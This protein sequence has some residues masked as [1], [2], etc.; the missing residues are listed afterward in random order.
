M[1]D[2][3]SSVSVVSFG[4]FEVDFQSRRLRKRGMRIRVEEQPFQILEILLNRPGQVVTRKAL[5]EKLWPNT[6]VGYEHSLNTAVN[7]MRE[8][9]GDS[10]QSPRF[11][12]TVPR[13][14]YRFIAPVR[15]LQRAS[16]PGEKKMLMA[17]PF[18][19][20]SDSRER[21]YFADGLTEEMI[22]QLGKLDPKR[23]GVI[24]RTSAI[25]Y[26]AAKKTI[27]EIAQEL[28]VDYILEGSVRRDGKRVR[29]TIQLIEAGAQT[30]L[31]SGSYDRHLLD[32]LNVQFEVARQIGRALAL[33][34]LPEDSSKSLAL[35]ASRARRRSSSKRHLCRSR[36]ALSSIATS[37]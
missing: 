17:L 37:W 6:I 26:K 10:A 23:L 1:K 15:K 3:Q 25:Q 14:G 2:P 36:L 24:A 13:V 32:V 21:D 27:G 16:S 11:I 30:H 12:E 22:S 31:W 20:L 19:N 29:I 35:E 18:E 9:L 7:K 5:C 8:L 4:I 34:L 33:E 28:N